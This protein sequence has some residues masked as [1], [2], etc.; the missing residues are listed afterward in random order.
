MVNTCCRCWT[1]KP[2][3]C[4]AINRALTIWSVGPVLRRYITNTSWL[5]M[6]NVVRLVVGLVV[7]ILVARYLG[8]ERYGML[9]Y[10]VA[11]VGLFS[12]LSSLGL[13][14]I[15]V[16]ELVKHPEQ[17][18]EI[19]GTAIVLRAIGTVVMMWLL[20]VVSMLM[21]QSEMTKVLIAIVFSSYCIQIFS[22][23]DWY[24]QAVVLSRFVVVS[25]MI[26]LAVSAMLKLFLLWLHASLVMFAFVS[27]IESLVFVSALI[28]FYSRQ[29]KK[30]VSWR[31]SLVCA[32]GL[33][34]Q[35]WPLILSGAA[36]MIQ[37][38]ID[39][40]MLGEMLGDHA[41]GQYSVAMRMIEVFAFIPVVICNSIAPEV[42]KWKLAGD[43]MYYHMLSNLY[44]LMFILF[45][46]IAVPLFFIASPIVIMLFGDAY[47]QAGGLLAL[48]GIRLFFANFGMVR[49]L[50][51]T[52]NELFR[53]AFLSSLLG[54]VMNVSLNYLLI[55]GYGA[56]GAIW[57]TII[58]FAVTIFLIDAFYR[59]TKENFYA[60]ARGILTPWKLSLRRI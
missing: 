59:D 46:L 10:A 2:L 48:L 55:P 32:K 17:Q 27:M 40:V 37:A 6:G 13:D 5:A 52:N 28:W 12:V 22:V 29:G 53:Y 34:G 8:P 7:G 49:G 45:L 47:Q 16:K 26:Q 9:S 42:T 35:S 19:L 1:G 15:V 31:A 58:S 4:S 14:G 54:A 51:I 25:Q 60:M 44:R 20:V 30:I 43:R 56:E 38:R 21:R 57:A 33:M 39:Q 50:F 18:D 3:K 24:F 36:I 41:V 11:F 23:L